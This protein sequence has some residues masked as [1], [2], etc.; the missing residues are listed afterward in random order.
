MKILWFTSTP[1][2]YEQ[3]MHFYHGG[4]WIDSLETI[5]RQKKGIELAVSFFHKTD[6]GKVDRDGKLYY[7]IKRRSAASNPI[8]WLINNHLGKSE[9]ETLFL[10][11]LLNVIIQFKPDIIH[12]FGTENIFA[13]IQ[14]YT[15][16]PVVIHLQGILNPYQ[17]AYFPPFTNKKLFSGLRYFRNILLGTAIKNRYKLFQSMAEREKIYFLQA[18]YLMGRT[19]WDRDVSSLMAPGAEYFHINEVLRP[20]FYTQKKEIYQKGKPIKIVSTLSET[21]YKGIDVVLKAACLLKNYPDI[22]FEWQIVGIDKNSPL[23]RCFER[24]FKIVH[25]SCSIV[26]LGKQSPEELTNLL[27]SADLFVHPSYIDNSPNS[28]CE[29]QIL[30]LPVIACNVGGLSTLIENNHTGLLIPSNGIYELTH[31]IVDY[32]QSPDKY[33]NYGKAAHEK[34]L[35]RHDK[36]AILGKLIETYHQ[37]LK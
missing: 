20:Q 32:N 18:K 12:I 15:A 9:N 8:R 17:N 5:L 37:I 33:Y 36:N 11:K 25:T 1:S 28:V 26:C 10:P 24:E 7:P 29:A 6:N 14:A 23:L 2:M 30:G 31:I 16:T 21:I 3:S 35:Y 19:A 27:L 22:D 13:S 4:G 34:A